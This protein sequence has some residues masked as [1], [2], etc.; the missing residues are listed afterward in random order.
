[1]NQPNPESERPSLHVDSDWKAQ[2][3]AERERLQ[4]LDEAHAQPAQD[5]GQLPPADFRSI[6]GIFASQAVGGLGAY[7]DP[8]SKRVIIDL[9]G[10]QFAIDLLAVLEAKTKGNLTAEESAELTAILNQLRAQF[11]QIAQLVAAQSAAGRT[12]VAPGAGGSPGRSE[13][14]KPKIIVPG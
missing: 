11:V 6:V 1:M 13:G 3:E 4:K 8:E 5:P 7:Q 12:T 14:S 10:S 2:A 9:A